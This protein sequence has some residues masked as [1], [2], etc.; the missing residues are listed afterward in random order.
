MAS[1]SVFYWSSRNR[2]V[3]FVLTRGDKIAA[4]EVKGGR[5]TS[6]LPG[7]AAF[8]KEFDVHKKLL[9]GKGGI[10]LEEFLL[11]DVSDWF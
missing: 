1:T 5:K 6:A 4:I 9:V 3:D 2:E 10:P 7:M 8:S 11:A